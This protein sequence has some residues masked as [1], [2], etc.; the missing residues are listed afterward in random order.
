MEYRPPQSSHTMDELVSISRQ[1]RRWLQ[2]WPRIRAELRGVRFNRQGLRRTANF[3]ASFSGLVLGAFFLIS[4]RLLV[5]VIFVAVQGYRRWAKWKIDRQL[6]RLAFTPPTAVS[7]LSVA[8]PKPNDATSAA[9]L[10]G[11]F[12]IRLPPEI[13]RR[14][15]VFAFGEKTLHIDL[16]YRGPLY[17]K[18]E[19]RQGF[20]RGPV[21]NSNF[22]WHHAQLQ[23]NAT[24][25]RSV[26]KHDTNKS[27][28]W[29]GCVCHRFP[30]S[31][32]DHLPLGRRR[33]HPWSKNRE[34]DDDLCLKGGGC[35]QEWLGDWPDGCRVGV[36][37][38]L[39]SCRQ[40]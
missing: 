5:I 1:W 2:E 28:E 12:F 37:G 15:L 36:M 8:S 33:N 26:R 19:M 17:D 40:A 11:T 25:W 16:E 27:W 32:P 9:A 23:A 22:S 39:L 30:A 7:A 3:C 31:G 29:Y 38:W 35:C 14:V 20:S 13:R 18:I 6:R 21:T 34:P 10:T 4:L 24:K